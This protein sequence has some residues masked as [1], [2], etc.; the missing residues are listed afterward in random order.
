TFTYEY[1]FV[2]SPDGRWLATQTSNTRPE[3]ELRHFVDDAEPAI[4][5]CV[6]ASVGYDGCTSVHGFRPDSR[7]LYIT[8]VAPAAEIDCDSGSVIARHNRIRWG[9]KTRP[10]AYDVGIAPN[11]GPST[12]ALPSVESWLISRLAPDAYHWLISQQA[13]FVQWTEAS[14]T[15]EYA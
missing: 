3:V 11:S 14:A 6:P 7:S 4:L 12:D 9:P 13:V 1:S 5:L 8:S 2:A 15:V 10:T